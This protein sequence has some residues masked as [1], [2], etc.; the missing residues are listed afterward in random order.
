[1][2]VK[3]F[4]ACGAKKKE[5]KLSNIEKNEEHVII[6]C[7]DLKSIFVTWNNIDESVSKL[8]INVP[9]DDPRLTINPYFLNLKVKL[10][11]KEI[12]FNCYTH[13]LWL[14]VIL[15]QCPNL[16]IL[17]FY[18]LTKEKVRH[19]AENFEHLRHIYCDYIEEATEEYYKELKSSNKDINQSIKIN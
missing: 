13:D 8:T 3:K 18:K 16:E 12:H 9:T 19:A 15:D 4:I 5:W 17:H 7:K 14:Q 10:N 6:Y 1:M 11:I 2:R